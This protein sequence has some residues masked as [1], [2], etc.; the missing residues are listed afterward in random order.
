[1]MTPLAQICMQDHVACYAKR[2]GYRLCAGLV[3]M[4]SHMFH[5]KLHCKVNKFPFC[6]H[7]C[8]LLADTGHCNARNGCE[9]FFFPSF[10]AVEQKVCLHIHSAFLGASKSMTGL[11]KGIVQPL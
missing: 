9:V 1:M 10:T 6:V 2:S 3:F 7:F 4:G 8:T 5:F 11:P